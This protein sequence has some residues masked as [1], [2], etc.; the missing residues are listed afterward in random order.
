MSSDTTTTMEERREFGSLRLRGRLWWLRYRMNGR[1]H[2]ESSHSTSRR[3]AEKLLDRRQA[4]LAIGNLTAPDAKRVTFTELADMIRDDY[5][6]RGRRSLVT[7][8]GSLANLKA[9]FGACRAIAITSDRITAYERERLDAGAARAT[10]NKELAALRRAFNLAVKARRLPPSAKPAISTPDPRNARTGFLEDSDFQAV[11]AEL[12]APLRPA[13][14]FAYWTGWRVQDEVMALTWIQ[15]DFA[16]GVVR[17]EPNTTKSDQG[18]TF[19]FTALP[20]LAALLERQRE[21]TSALERRNGCV[22]P[23]VFHRNGKPIRSCYGAWLAACQRAA[24]VKREGLTTVVRPRLLGRTPHDFRRTAARNLIRAGVPQ[25]VVMKLCGWKTDA[26]FRRYA[27]VDERDLR[28][29]VELLAKGT[30]GGQSAKKVA[31]AVG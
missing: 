28:D 26:M 23:H 10:V 30:T 19:P 16:A 29:A 6:V 24:T 8:E 15:V 11:L 1:E 13:L 25:H 17:L 31:K 14:Q 27:I 20:E 4:E 7:L 21:H 12:P 22:I 18:R 2:W 9:F 3:E 5:K